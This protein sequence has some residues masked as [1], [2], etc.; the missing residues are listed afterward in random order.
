MYFAHWLMAAVW[1]TVGLAVPPAGLAEEPSTL[2]E[3]VGQWQVEATDPATGKSE[4]L[5][6]DVRRFAGQAWLSGTGQSEDPGFESKDVWGIDPITKEV[7]RIVFLGSGTYAIVRSPGWK[8]RTLV[9]EGDA[10]SENGVMRVRETIK[11][12]NRDEFHATWEAQRDGTW[13]AYSVEKVTRLP[14]S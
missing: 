6:Y 12:V 5:R 9:L 4:K 10:R 3:L 7:I 13:H 11:W 1:I 14:A 2:H 8:D